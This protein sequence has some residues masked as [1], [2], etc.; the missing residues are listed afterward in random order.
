MH[1]YNLLSVIQIKDIKTFEDINEVYIN[2]LCRVDNLDIY[3]ELYTKS[4]GVLE[5]SYTR[6]DRDYAGFEVEYFYIRFIR[7][8][9][10]YEK[11]NWFKVV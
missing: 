6:G 1:I 10:Y 3:R 5:T 2:I 8:Y 11:Y 7:R 4:L 9:A